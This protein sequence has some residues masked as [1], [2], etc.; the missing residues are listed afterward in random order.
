MSVELLIALAVVFVAG[1]VAGLTG[2][3]LTLISVP[4]LLLVFDPVTVVVVNSI[5]S[6]VTGLVIVFEA[7]R[8]IEMN[9]VLRLLPW[10]FIG[11]VLGSE[12]LSAL[13]PDYIKLGAGIVVLCAALLLVSKVKLP[14][15]SSWS[16][17][18]VGASSG[19]LATSTGFP[20]PLVALLFTARRFAKESLRASSAAYF[21]SIGAIGL[22]VLI[23][24]GLA[25]ETHFTLAALFIPAALLGKILGSILLRKFSNETFRK[26]TLGVSVLAGAM[27]ISTALLALTT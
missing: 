13:D 5:L 11:L 3:G 10:S 17:V 26:I 18:V 23:G 1:T 15:D 2:F 16:V 19:T 21:S 4:A 14:K 6:L 27:G 7:W 9:A 12:L 8:E 20:S 25:E 22:A 24:R